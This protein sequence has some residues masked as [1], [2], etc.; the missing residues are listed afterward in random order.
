MVGEADADA[1]S[2]RA[3]GQHRLPRHCGALSSIARATSRAPLLQRAVVAPLVTEEE[4][5]PTPAFG[6]PASPSSSLPGF[7]SAL[8]LSQARLEA[9]RA[10]SI[11]PVSG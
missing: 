7:S 4:I 11:A 9:R 10:T 3:R 6:A 5:R 8:D 2:S 1:T